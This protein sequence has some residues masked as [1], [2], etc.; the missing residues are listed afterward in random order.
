LIDKT[1]RNPQSV[2]LSD[3]QKINILDQ[4]FNN[5]IGKLDMLG[6]HRV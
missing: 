2:G 6:K 1:Q 3:D 4:K 5:L